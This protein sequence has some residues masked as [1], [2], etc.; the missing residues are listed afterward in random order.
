MKFEDDFET[1]CRV[2]LAKH[3]SSRDN[4]VRLTKTKCEI[5]A[6]PAWKKGK[7]GLTLTKKQSGAL[8]IKWRGHLQLSSEETEQCSMGHEHAVVKDTTWVYDYVTLQKE[9][10]EL[11]KEF[12]V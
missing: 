1:P 11:L 3:D 5:S 9:E 8:E 2:V 4:R 6:E 12:L 7:C 10:V